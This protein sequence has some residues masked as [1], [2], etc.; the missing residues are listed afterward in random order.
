LWALP[1][2]I[3]GDADRTF[4]ALIGQ[5]LGSYARLDELVEPSLPVTVK[6]PRKP[7]YRPSVD[8]NPLGAWYWKSQVSGAAGGPLAGKTVAIKDN[9]CFAG[10]PMMNGTVTLE[11]YV[12]EADATI[13]TRILDAGGT[14]LGPFAGR[15]C[16]LGF[17][18][19]PLGVLAWHRYTRF[20]EASPRQVNRW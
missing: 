2:A 1:A 12:P 11:G 14:I 13:V 5:T 9:V 20:A 18:H 15:C 3:Q 19:F 16:R 6:Y 8:D 7:G 17:P 10:V 4:R